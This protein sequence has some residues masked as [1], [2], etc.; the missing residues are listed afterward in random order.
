M[1]SSYLRMRCPVEVTMAR[2]GRWIGA[3]ELGPPRL[4]ADE[5]LARTEQGW[6]W[7]HR[8]A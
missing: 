7:I 2:Y 1:A 6:L 8:V 5:E 3:P 4:E